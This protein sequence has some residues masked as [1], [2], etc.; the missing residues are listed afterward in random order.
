MNWGIFLI[1]EIGLFALCAVQSVQYYLDKNYAS[2]MASSYLGGTIG[3]LTDITSMKIN[4]QNALDQLN[5]Y[6]YTGNPT[7]FKHSAYSNFDVI[8][9]DIQKAISNI[10]K[11]VAQYGSPSDKGNA[12]AYQQ[13][14]ANTKASAME[15]EARIDETNANRGWNPY[16]NPVGYALWLTTF[17]VWIPVW[18]VSSIIEERQYQ[19]KY[20]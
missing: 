12:Y 8:K 2:D 5:R 18:I 17:L 15:L 10:D 14:V 4:L 20:A 11:Y 19:R 6:D 16:D 9:A 13:T 3:S 7:L 1:I